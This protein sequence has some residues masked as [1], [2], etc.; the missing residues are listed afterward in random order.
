MVRYEKENIGVTSQSI[1]YGVYNITRQTL[2]YRR[3]TCSAGAPRV[4]FNTL[5][6]ANEILKLSKSYW[7]PS[8]QFTIIKQD[9]IT[10]ITDTTGK[11]QRLANGIMTLHMY[12][13]AFCSIEDQPEQVEFTSID[14]IKK[15]KAFKERLFKHGKLMQLYATKDLEPDV[16]E[17]SYSK[18]LFGADHW[19][20]VRLE[21]STLDTYMKAIKMLNV[22]APWPAEK[23]ET[24]E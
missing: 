7:P 15:D 18:H 11:I 6:E 21:T 22:K 19:C 8:D 1:T 2:E 13:P 17:N 3:G 14:D 4:W 16:H 10:T 20:R 5:E 23:E 24:D 9:S 12:Y